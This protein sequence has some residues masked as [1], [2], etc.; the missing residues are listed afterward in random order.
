MD[1]FY[2][3][4][5]EYVNPETGVTSILNY[6]DSPGPPRGA[7]TTKITDFLRGLYNSRVDTFAPYLKKVFSN[8]KITKYVLVPVDSISPDYKHV[9]KKIRS[10]IRSRGNLSDE[11][12]TRLLSDL[13]QLESEFNS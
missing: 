7:I 11:A 3:Y 6:H 5:L 9:F 2:L 12:K 1:A 4:V 10:E 8:Y 13:Q